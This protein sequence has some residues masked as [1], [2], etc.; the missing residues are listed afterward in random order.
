MLGGCRP[1][2]VAKS[3]I[4]AAAGTD[5]HG[6]G[7]KMVGFYA[8]PGSVDDLICLGYLVESPD[9][10][11]RY[12]ATK[13]GMRFAGFEMKPLDDVRGVDCQCGPY[14]EPCAACES[15][16]QECSGAGKIWYD[17]VIDGELVP[18]FQTMT[19][20]SCNGSG[21]SPRSKRID[22]ICS[23]TKMKW[24]RKRSAFSAVVTVLRSVL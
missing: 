16:C 23:N 18:S 2:S 24:N 8:A 21:W 1:P 13:R 3:I 9:H 20:L 5:R 15:V 7:G 6:H 11:E 22:E 14:R 10:P 12:F 4:R 19:C 17:H